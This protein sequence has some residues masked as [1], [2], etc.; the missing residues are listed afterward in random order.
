M[1]KENSIRSLK[2]L[3]CHWQSQQLF[4]PILL[5]TKTLFPQKIS[6]MATPE[7]LF[8]YFFFHSLS[9]KKESKQ[10]KFHKV[11]E[12]TFLLLTVSATFLPIFLETK[13]LF[14]QKISVMATPKVLFAYFF[15]HSLSFKKESEQRKF[16]KVSEATFPLLS[17]PATF[18]PIFLETKT[19]FPQ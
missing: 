1:G 7:V 14:P 10:R 5:E 12:G 8:A 15:F 13:T 18:P 4:H 17:A 16:R 2:I 19:L 6:V 11:S 3:F 9:F